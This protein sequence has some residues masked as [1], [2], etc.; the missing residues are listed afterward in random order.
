[1]SKNFCT[2][3]VGGSSWFVSSYGRIASS[4]L[5]ILSTPLLSSSSS[6]ANAV[7]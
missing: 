7:L 5:S 2:S 3:G 4:I 1:M 6:A